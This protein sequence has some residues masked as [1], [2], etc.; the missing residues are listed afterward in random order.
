ME[1]WDWSGRGSLQ[2]GF[3]F[4]SFL[5]CGGLGKRGR[6]PRDVGA[7]TV[8]D[9]LDGEDLKARVFSLP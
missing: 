4:R 2:E 1:R 3:L 5:F 6:A 8:K 7:L 9:V